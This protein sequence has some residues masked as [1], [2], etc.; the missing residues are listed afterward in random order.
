MYNNSNIFSSISKQ[1]DSFDN[2]TRDTMDFIIYDQQI[3]DKLEYSLKPHHKNSIK[4]LNNK[5]VW[6]IMK[7]GSHIQSKTPRYTY[8]S[9][10][11]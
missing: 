11:G 10:I 4:K 7:W 6:E 8:P 3:T 5:K 1:E 2:A 9:N